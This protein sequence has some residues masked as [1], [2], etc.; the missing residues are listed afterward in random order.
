MSSLNSRSCKP[1][2]KGTPALD[3]AAAKS[4]LAELPGDW[5]ITG[6]TKLEKEFKFPNFKEALAFTNKVGEIAEREGHHPD[7]HLGWGRV[8]LEIWTHSV[9]GLSDN[10]F[11][12]AAKLEG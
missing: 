7:I 3:S 8:K 11:I 9:G 2:K 1:C 6:G 4:L 10:D 5:K 12:L